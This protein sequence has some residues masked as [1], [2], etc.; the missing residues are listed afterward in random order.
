MSGFSLTIKQLENIL[1]EAKSNENQED[2]LS[3]EVKNSRLIVSQNDWGHN[4]IKV[5]VNKPC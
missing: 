4:G 3:F 5:L 1:K 2:I